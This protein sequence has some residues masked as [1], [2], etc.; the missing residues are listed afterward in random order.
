MSSKWKSI[1][2]NI[3][4][5][6]FIASI[7]PLLFITTPA[8]PK[9]NILELLFWVIIEIIVD[10]KIIYVLRY[11]KSTAVTMSSTVHLSVIVVLGIYKAVWVI[12]IATIIVEVLLKKPLKKVLFNSGQYGLNI[13]VGGYLFYFL[14][15]SPTTVIFNYVDIPAILIASFAYFFSN[16]LIIAGVICLNFKIKFIQYIIEE[17]KTNF[18]YIYTMVPLSIAMAAIY[19]PRFPYFTLIMF[20]PILMSDQVLRKYFDIQQ[21]THETLKLAAD[22]LD[23]RDNYTFA[24]SMRVAEYAKKIAIQMDLTED[25]VFEIEMAGQV[26]DLG[27]IAIEDDI[28]RK[29]GKLT[30]EE[31]AQIKR[32]PEV[33]YEL[34]NKLKHYR[35]GAAFILYHHERLDGKGYPKGLSGK[36]IPLGAKILAVADS[37]DA[38]TSDR[39]YRKALLQATAVEELR[40]NSGTQF[41]H[42]VVNAFVRVLKEDYGFEEI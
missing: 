11:N 2:F 7:I 5:Y 26:H 36:D 3:Y 32:H 30:E 14:K 13:L 39:P 27:K 9:S 12:V 41:D 24:H 37:Y 6:I 15:Q 19:D 8:I 29:N 18:V 10:A 23:K 25:K 40:S 4:V 1:I 17:T 28:L 21:E 22:I 42:E 16:L 31:F 20:P 34:L 33:G 35:K 38:M